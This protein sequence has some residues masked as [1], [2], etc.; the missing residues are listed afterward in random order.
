MHIKNYSKILIIKHG[1]LGDFIL[2]SGPFKSIRKYH[3]SAHICLLTTLPYKTIAESCPWFDEV[4]I[5]N[6]PK[7]FDFSGWLD[8]RKFIRNNNWDRIYDFQHN[9]RS[10]ICFSF[11][12]KPKPEWSG[13]AKGCSH[14][15][16]NPNRNNL[17]TIERQK[18]QLSIAGVKELYD[19][20][21]SWLTDNTDEIE[22]PNIF[23]LIVPG[24]SPHRK[25]KRWP[26]KHYAELC[27][28]L[29][30]NNIVPILIG[31]HAEKSELEYI[32]SI[33]NNSINL[34]GKTSFGQV[35][36]IAR[37]ASF[38]IGNDTGPM[39][40]ISSV[41]CKSIVLFSNESNPKQTAPRGEYVEIL[42]SNHL[43]NLSVQIVFELIKKFIKKN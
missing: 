35:A 32:K 12:S 25:N 29:Y 5:D 38:A 26:S 3:S 31:N 39:H 19:T 41:G 37:K 13:I 2:C 4:I 11:L 43:I 18:E 22:L 36:E 6:K 8:L 9:D 34:C 7:V 33:E 1:A 20:D 21:V 28:I 30:S 15:H 24:G 14:P 10:K 23:A 42:E 40:I 16:I 27:K 17:H